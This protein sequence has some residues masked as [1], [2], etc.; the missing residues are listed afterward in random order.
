MDETT[1]ATSGRAASASSDDDEAQEIEEEKA[2]A[3]QTT[4]QE[5]WG[6]TGP[7]NKTPVSQG[8]LKYKG[9]S[10]G[11]Q[12]PPIGKRRE[13]LD[14]CYQHGIVPSSIFPEWYANEWGAPG[15]S[16][17]LRKMANCLNTFL[18]TNEKKLTPS[19]EP[20]EDWKSDLAYLRSKYYEGNYSDSESPG[21]FGWPGGLRFD[22]T[23]DFGPSR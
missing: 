23:D 14:D 13:I 18:E 6:G 10:V 15:T 9:Y 8:Y 11:Q 3:W 4:V 22:R 2:E 1:T 7:M 5:S 16:A 20:I 17:R 19:T 21:F 12:G